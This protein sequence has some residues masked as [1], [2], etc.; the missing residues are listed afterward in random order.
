M[1]PGAQSS[2][3][4]AAFRSRQGMRTLWARTLPSGWRLVSLG[5]CPRALVRCVLCAFSEFA[6]PGGCRSLAPVL[7]PWLWPVACHSGVPR[8]PAWCAAPRPVRCSGRLS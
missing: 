2:V 7:V 1:L 4:T 8:G 6:A 5:T 3:W